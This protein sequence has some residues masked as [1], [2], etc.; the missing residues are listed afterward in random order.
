MNIGSHISSSNMKS[1]KVNK[2]NSQRESM[3]SHSSLR[4]S[5]ISQHLN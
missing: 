1:S 3:K 5:A 4:Y 2:D